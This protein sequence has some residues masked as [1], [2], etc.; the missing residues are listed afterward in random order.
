MLGDLI[1]TRNQAMDLMT[2]LP[3]GS[4]MI[5]TLVDGHGAC[6]RTLSL[7]RHSFLMQRERDQA[8]APRLSANGQSQAVPSAFTMA[9]PS[10][11][12]PVSA[13]DSRPLS[14][15]YDGWMLQVR[16]ED[17]TSMSNLAAQES[18]PKA[19]VAIA[20]NAPN[21]SAT[22]PPAATVA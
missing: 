12:R 19:A 7:N 21:P 2:P 14:P 13:C 6:C 16:G 5:G 22:F 10:T 3:T 17:D 8:T 4:P 1:R 20:A 15:G 11:S 18:K 9:C